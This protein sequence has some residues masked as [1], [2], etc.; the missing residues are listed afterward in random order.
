MLQLSIMTMFMMKSFRQHFVYRSNTV[1]LALGS[2]LQLF[3]LISVWRGLFA[4]QESIRGVTYDDMILFVLVNMLVGTLT[5]SR[6]AAT[7]GDKV[8][9]GS[10]ST[11]LIRPVSFKTYILAD[12]WGENLFRLLFSAIPACVVY[13]AFMS[14]PSVAADPLRILLFFISAAGGIAIIYHIHYLLGLTSFWTGN[15]YYVEWFMRAFFELFAGTFVPLWFYPQWLL[16]IGHYLPFRLVTFEPIAILAGR[17]DI[18]GAVGILL[19][20]GLWIA[21]L[22]LIENR[23][24]KMAQNKVF[25][26]GG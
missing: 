3:V 6:I 25:I 13:F 2:F 19:L 24:W 21:I 17:T 8:M 26:Q 4:G 7:I 18:R 12:Q 20:Q 9:T 1:I 11:D 22:L 10:I 16:S 5:H 23:V 14:V 15:A